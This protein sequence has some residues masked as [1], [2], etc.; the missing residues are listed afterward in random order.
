[1]NC[2]NCQHWSPLKL[3]GADITSEFGH[4]ASPHLQYDGEAFEAHRVPPEWDTRSV[5]YGDASAYKCELV[6]GKN[7]GCIHFTAKPP[8]P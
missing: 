3:Y 8:Y 6:T 2:K 5:Y 4:C 1:M 7:F